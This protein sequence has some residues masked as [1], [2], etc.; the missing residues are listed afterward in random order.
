MLI[1]LVIIRIVKSIL[2]KNKSKLR[3]ER[4]FRSTTLN[5]SES[6][7]KNK[8]RK[9]FLLRVHTYSTLKQIIQGI[10]FFYLH[11]IAYY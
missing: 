7:V 4:N 6:K 5:S 11:S 8:P 9:G 1:R 3:L 10:T 2:Q